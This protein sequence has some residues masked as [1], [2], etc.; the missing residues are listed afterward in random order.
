MPGRFTRWPVMG[1]FLRPRP[2]AVI[3]ERDCPLFEEDK[4]KVIMEFL[5][6]AGRS[7][8]LIIEAYPVLKNDHIGPEGPCGLR[9]PDVPYWSMGLAPFQV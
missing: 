8:R 5:S 3:W 4:S 2:G 6:V 9:F 1:R 7:I